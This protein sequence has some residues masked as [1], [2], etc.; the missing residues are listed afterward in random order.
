MK[1][2]FYGVNYM[3]K[4]NSN[5]NDGGSCSCDNTIIYKGD[6]TS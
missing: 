1:T 2:R 5:I 4:I 3:N 6:C